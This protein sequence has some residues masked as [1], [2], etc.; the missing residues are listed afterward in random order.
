MP[1]PVGTAATSGETDYELQ[2]AVGRTALGRVQSTTAF[3][4]FATCLQ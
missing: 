4:V 3:A 2:A 1:D